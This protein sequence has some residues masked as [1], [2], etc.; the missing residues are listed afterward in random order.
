MVATLQSQG[1][2]IFLDSLSVFAANSG[3]CFSQK[4]IS[5]EASQLPLTKPN[6]KVES[7]PETVVST[8]KEKEATNSDAKR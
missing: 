5:K 8:E 2:F 6:E 7:D 3:D 1:F 4:R